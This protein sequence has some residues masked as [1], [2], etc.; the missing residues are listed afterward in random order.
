MNQDTIPD[1]DQAAS[2]LTAKRPS[3]I[4][5]RAA[6]T[7]DVEAI[8]S[9]WIHGWVDAHL[10]NVPPELVASRSPSSFRQRTAERVGST[11]VA[12]AAGDVAGFVTLV[13]N[14][15]EQ[16]YVAAPHRGRGVA[17]ALLIAAER[18]IRAAGHRSAWRAVGPGN[19]RARWFDERMGWRDE[20]PIEYLAQGDDG[21]IAVPTHRYTKA[22]D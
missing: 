8:A 9:V 5:I 4:T 18:R 12:V 15:V 14:E 13:G 20:G 6:Q 10:G 17:D 11:M 21:P 2:D 7:N 1:H 3:N 19:L 16:L 22:L